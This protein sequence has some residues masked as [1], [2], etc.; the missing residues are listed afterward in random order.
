MQSPLY[1]RGMSKEQEGRA[2]ALTAIQ[3][4]LAN[5]SITFEAEHKPV[6]RLSLGPEGIIFEALSMPASAAPSPELP[7]SQEASPSK[8]KEKTVILTGKLKAKPKE[9]KP[10]RRGRPTAYARL[11]AHEEGQED[12]HLYLATFHRHT[13]KIALSLAKDAQL[14]VEGYPHLSGDPSGKRMDTLSVINIVQYPGKLQ[15]GTS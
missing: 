9:G 4:D 10:D 5:R 11:A 6:A 13:T 12:P 7:S 3:I 1:S 2:I 15:K 8:E 14:T